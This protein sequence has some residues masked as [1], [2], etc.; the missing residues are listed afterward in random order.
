MSAIQLIHETADTVTLK[1]ADYEALLAKLED[2]ADIEVLN[3]AAEREAVLGKEKGREDHLPIELAERLFAGEHPIRIW[4]EH[5]KLSISALA[6]LA[7]I[8]RSYLTEIETNQKPG[9]AKAYAAIAK[10]LRLPIEAMIKG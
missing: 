3:D 7:G 9:S 1:R 8:S 5:R 4:R 6:E 10:V 2:A